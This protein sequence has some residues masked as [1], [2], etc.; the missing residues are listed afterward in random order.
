MRAVDPEI[1]FQSKYVVDED[2][3]WLW[4]GSIHPK[5]YGRFK[6]YGQ[7]L[8]AHRWSYAAY[9]GSIPANYDIDHTCHSDNTLDCRDLVCKHRRCVNPYHLEAVDRKTHGSRSYHAAKSHCKNGHEFNELNTRR[10][11][12][13]RICKVCFRD[14]Q[15]ALRL[16]AKV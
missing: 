4:Q 11:G 9:R 13:K 8:K 3:C 7:M 10:E 1:R 6:V 5:G 16:E 12:S 15:A 2:G 14:Y